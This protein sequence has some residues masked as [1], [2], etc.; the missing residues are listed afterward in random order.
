MTFFWFSEALMP[1]RSFFPG[2]SEGSINLQMFIVAMAFSFPAI[3]LLLR[4]TRRFA[5]A[6]ATTLL[7][8]V[9]PSYVGAMHNI[10]G[11]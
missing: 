11:R 3:W 8:I 9:V 6:F 7:I 1:F 5:I 4:S 10:Y 2:G